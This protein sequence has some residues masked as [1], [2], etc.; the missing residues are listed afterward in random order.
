MSHPRAVANRER[1]VRF[2]PLSELFCYHTPE[3]DGPNSGDSSWYTSNDYERFQRQ[4]MH[5]KVSYL[6]MKIKMKANNIPVAKCIMPFGFEKELISK[7]YTEK[8]VRKRKLVML[9]VLREQARPNR[10]GPDKQ[11][12]I[13]NASMLHSEWARVQARTIGYCQAMQQQ[14]PDY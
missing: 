10:Y 8:R 1:T 5:E 2:S 11:E 9:A 12:R 14:L 7:H 3:E 6:Q 13:A 4:A